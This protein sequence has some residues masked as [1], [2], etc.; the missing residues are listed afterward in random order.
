MGGIKSMH[1]D[2]LSCVRVKRVESERFGIDSRVRQSCIMPPW[3][4]NIYMNAVMEK[5]KMGM[6][7]RGECGDYLASYMQMTWFC[8]V[9]R[10]RT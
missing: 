8:V 5:V 10:K 3:L 9:S 1:V 6:G 2:S 7:R 4:F